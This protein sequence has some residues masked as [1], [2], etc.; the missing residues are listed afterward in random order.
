M[1]YVAIALFLVA[2]IATFVWASNKGSDEQVAVGGAFTAV[3]GFLASLLFAAIACITIVK[4]GHVGVEILFGHVRPNVH[5]AGLHFVNPFC[6][7]EKMSVQ[8]DN[9]W[10]S[11]Q[12]SEGAKKHDDSVSVRSSNGLQMPVDVSVP[13]RL[14]PESAPWVY[15]NLGKDYVEKILRVSLSTACRRAAS[16]YTA[17][18]L[19]STK[20]DEFADKTRVLLGEELNKLLN[21]NYKGKNPP[22][23]VLVISQVL[24]GHVGI[25]ETVKNA[26]ETK[27]KGDQEQQAMDFRIMKEKKE[28]ERKRVEAE[29]IKTFQDIV[30]KGIDEKL[31]RWKAIDA[32][33]HLAESP[34]SKVIIIGS[35]AD[36]LPVLLGSQQLKEQPKK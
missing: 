10:M 19:Y 15:E 21:D 16:H 14:I 25:P 12:E 33:V 29:G 30:S 17:E 26:I 7:V 13:Y 9:Y 5:E 4:P 27:L 31:L 35:G 20:R 11:H 3:I 24:I 22:E 36:G 8:T 2:L 1:I 18:E 28:A 23:Q 34:N 6:S 32:T